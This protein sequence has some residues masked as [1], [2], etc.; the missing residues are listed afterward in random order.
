[1]SCSS[2]TAAL[3]PDEEASVAGITSERNIP[4]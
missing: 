1:M 4:I 3:H 2:G